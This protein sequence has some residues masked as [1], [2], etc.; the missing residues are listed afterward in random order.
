[1][2][3]L[4]LGNWNASAY[5]QSC[6]LRCVMEKSEM[7]ASPGWSGS[8]DANSSVHICKFL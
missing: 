5:L 1:M 3:A 6:M 2:Q 7:D 8:D 4:C